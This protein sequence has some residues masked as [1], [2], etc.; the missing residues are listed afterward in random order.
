MSRRI[1]GIRKCERNNATEEQENNA[2]VIMLGGENDKYERNEKKGNSLTENE[3]FRCALV[4][5]V[6]ESERLKNNKMEQIN[7]ESSNV[8]ID[9]EI[10]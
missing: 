1:I 5:A 9:K 4:I 6:D 3:D 2:G 8:E 10:I 7:P